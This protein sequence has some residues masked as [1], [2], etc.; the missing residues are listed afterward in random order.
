MRLACESRLPLEGADLQALPQQPGVVLLEFG[1]GGSYLGQTKRLDRRVPRLLRTAGEAASA[2]KV[3]W[4]AVGS[5]FEANYLLW[6]LGE[7]VWGDD[8]RRRLRLRGAPLLKLHVG[9]RFPR[10]S[11]T[12][13]LAGGRAQYFGPF[14][15]RAAAERF[16]GDFLDFFLVRRC[17]ENL[18]PAP[19][20]PGCVYGEIGKCARPCQQH[21]EESEYRA[22]SG[23]LAMALESRG[24]SLGQ[25]LEEEREAASESL[26][27]EKAAAAHAKLGRLQEALRNAEIAA[28]LDALHGVVI[29]RAEGGVKLFPVYRSFLQEPLGVDLAPSSGRPVPLDRRLR[30]I[31]EAAPFAHGESRGREDSLALLNRWRRSSWRRGELLMIDGW[32]RIPF[33]RLVNAVGRVAAGRERGGAKSKFVA[34]ADTAKAEDPKPSA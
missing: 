12:S 13:R 28:D 17:W 20:H 7:R 30:E 16:Q 27:F 3:S 24:A 14:L 34:P 26:E 5:A 2:G 22:E 10:T 18:D 8:Y 23:R 9:N 1:G 4:Q 31:F 15:T 32:D 29:Q 11:I 33:R 21:V 25:A 19:N 6:R